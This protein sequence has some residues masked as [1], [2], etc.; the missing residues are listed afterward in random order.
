VKTCTNDNGFIT[1]QPCEVKVS[2]TV[3]ADESGRRL[4][5]LV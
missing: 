3:R 2:S 5:G 4:F 1:E